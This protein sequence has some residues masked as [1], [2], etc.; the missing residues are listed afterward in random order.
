MQQLLRQRGFAI[1]KNKPAIDEKL[2][3]VGIA[4][5]SL[6]L[7]IYFNRIYGLDRPGAF[8]S[9]ANSIRELQLAFDNLKREYEQQ[10]QRHGKN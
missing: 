1:L 3:L 6:S 2:D 5:A 8:L 4:A 9:V 7:Q 10:L